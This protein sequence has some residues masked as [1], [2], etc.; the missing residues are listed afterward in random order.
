MPGM[1]GADF[2]VTQ[3]EDSGAVKYG[4]SWI[5]DIKARLKRFS[6]PMFNLETGRF[7][8]DVIDSAMLKDLVTPGSYTEVTVNSKGLVTAGSNPVEQKAA[9][10]FRAVFTATSRIYETE[11]GIST[12]AAPDVSG[13]YTGSG[14]PYKGA[15]AALNGAQWNQYNFAIP[16]GVRRVKATIVGGGGGMNTNGTTYGGGG[17]EMVE[18]VIDVEDQPTL[19]VV[20]GEGGANGDPGQAGGASSV[21]LSD[22]VYAEAGGGAG[23]SG[24]AGGASVAGVASTTNLNVLRVTGTD[25]AESAGGLSGSIYRGYGTGSPEV[26]AD[27]VGNHGLVV[28]EW[29]L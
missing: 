13:T 2:D 15:Y 20:V 17:A 16:T 22:T 29:V 5:R 18:V 1:F 12:A 25:G 10:I 21:Y 8:N 7:K 27:G 14:T 6:A 26:P 9:R 23:G 19:T 4:A 24:S 11:T 28:L 3:P